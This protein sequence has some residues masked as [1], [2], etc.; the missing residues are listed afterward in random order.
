MRDAQAQPFVPLSHCLMES[1][2][3]TAREE[4]RR[5]QRSLILSVLLQS[6]LVSAAVV[7]PL[8]ASQK[9]VAQ[10]FAGTPIPIFKPPAPVPPIQSSSGSPLRHGPRSSAMPI[11][12]WQPPRI[13]DRVLELNDL[14]D[15]L[16]RIVS[17]GPGTGG[18]NLPGVGDPSLFG[19]GGTHAPPVPPVERTPRGPLVVGGSVQAAKLIHRVEPRYPPLMQ[20]IRRSGRVELRAIIARDGTVRELEVVGGDAGFVQDALEAVAQ[21]RYQPTLLNDEP[22]EVE[23]HITVIFVMRVP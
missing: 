3:Q 7:A 16:P 8:F 17:T 19:V 9:L 20:Q 14:Q 13:P 21:W 6:A 15:G 5:R 2:P 10:Q 4:R 18:T 22:V 23:T 1:D 12:I 11:Q